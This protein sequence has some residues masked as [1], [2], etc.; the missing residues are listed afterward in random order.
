MPAPP[1]PDRSSSVGLAL[2]E[3]A[4]HGAEMRA[5]LALPL[6]EALR[7]PDL[8]LEALADEDR[9]VGDSGIGAELFRQHDAAVRIDLQ[10]AALAVEGRGEALVVLREGLEDGSRRVGD[11]L[12]AAARRRRRSP[13]GRAPDSSRRRPGLRAPAPPETAPAPT[14]D[15][16]GRAGSRM[17][18]RN[19]PSPLSPARRRLLR[20][21]K[22]AAASS[23]G[24]ARNPPAS[25]HDRT[26]AG[27]LWSI[28]G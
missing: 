12:P 5:R 1:C 13:A 7:L 15:L 28:M 2:A 22:H 20:R 24:P 23:L 25:R 16:S 6:G 9:R 8:E 21:R 4:R 18:R 10:D 11:R 14:P 19:R 27:M 3:A 26:I 17:W